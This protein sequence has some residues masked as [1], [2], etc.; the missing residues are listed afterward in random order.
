MD[1]NNGYDA[2]ALEG[3]Q[4]LAYCRSAKR[5]SYGRALGKLRFVTF[6]WS[7]EIW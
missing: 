3:G 4:L 2:G 7:S 5:F 6:F 1:D